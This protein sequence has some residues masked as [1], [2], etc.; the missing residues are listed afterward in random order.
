VLQNAVKHFNVSTEVVSDARPVVQVK[1]H[2]SVT[3]KEEL[4]CHEYIK[5]QNASRSASV[6]FWCKNAQSAGKIGKDL[7]K[8][9]KIKQRMNELLGKADTPAVLSAREILEE[10]SRLAKKKSIH[11]KERIRALELLGKYRKLFSERI[12]VEGGGTQLEVLVIDAER[13]NLGERIREFTTK[14]SQTNERQR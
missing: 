9:P 10:L 2:P 7:L 1:P 12:E 13:T 4:F 5:D 6:A 8:R 14:L 3:P 11:P